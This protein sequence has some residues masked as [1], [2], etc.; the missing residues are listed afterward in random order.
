[1]VILYCVS[2]LEK[3]DADNLASALTQKSFPENKMQKIDL[4]IIL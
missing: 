4:N 1:M 2:I 3:I